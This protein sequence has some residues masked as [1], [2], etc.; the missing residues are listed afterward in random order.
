RQRG[1]IVIAIAHRPSALAGVDQLL[2]MSHG[3]IV[4]CGPKDD[5][6]ATIVRSAPQKPGSLKVVGGPEKT[7]P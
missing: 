7:A 2:V 6:L 4:H 5:V 1:G 3:R